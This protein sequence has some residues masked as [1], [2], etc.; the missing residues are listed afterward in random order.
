MDIC[1]THQYHQLTDLSQLLAGPISDNHRNHYVDVLLP[2]GTT[3]EVVMMQSSPPRLDFA[4]DRGG[5]SQGRWPRQETLTLLDIRSRLD[6]KFRQSS[7]KAP[8]WD[9]VS[10]IMAEE[11]GYERSGKKCREKLENLYK[12]YK[13]T[14]EG[15]AGKQDGKHYR[16][17]RQLE[18]LYGGDHKRPMKC[19]NIKPNYE[20]AP[21]PF[22]SQ[23]FSFSTSTEYKITTSSSSS[24]SGDEL[25]LVETKSRR[26]RRGRKKLKE[27]LEEQVRRLMELQEAW[28]ERMLRALERMEKERISR[29]ELWRKQ[30]AARLD[31]EHRDWAS[32]RAVLE[33]RDAALLAAL[34]NISCRSEFKRV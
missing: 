19:A 3:P 29:E 15:K 11:Y 4:D 1:M 13:K 17:F 32:E 12:Y 22:S 9:E 30:E 26:H 34:E 14:K 27:C 7:Q 28:L 18:A 21:V 23:S 20:E 24:S 8:L 31:R 10:R 5:S 33:A 16:F 2:C 6:P 25:D